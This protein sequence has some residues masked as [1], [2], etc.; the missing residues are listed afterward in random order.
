MR[1]PG[2]ARATSR[3]ARIV[4]WTA[5]TV[6]CLLIA[7]GV[8]GYLVIVR[9][10]VARHPQRADAILVLGPSLPARVAQAVHLAD[11]LHIDQLVVSIGDTGGQAK[12]YPC[13]GPPAGLTVT[14][15]KPS[16]YTTQGEARELGSLAADRNWHNVIVIA[17]TPQISRA[18]ML[19]K[20]CFGGTV[21]MVATPGGSGVFNWV[22]QFL[23]QSGAYVKAL[24]VKRG[25]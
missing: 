1:V 10:N 2:V 14:C 13:V 21:Q 4:R 15:F 23:H 16:P 7:W 12:G 20:R 25:C 9:P 17:P 6:L 11:T 24:V 5:A 18:H 22:G 19:M 8:V 3:S